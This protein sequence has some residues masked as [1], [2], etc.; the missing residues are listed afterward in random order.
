MKVAVVT[1]GNKGIG[2]AIVKGLCEKYEGLVYLTARDVGR[3]EAAVAE[4]KKLGLEPK[5][6]Q[7]DITDQESLDSFRDFIKKE[8]GGIDILVNN[9]AMA[10]KINATEPF[11]EK[12]EKTLYVNYFSLLKTCDTLFPLL[13]PHARV[14][15]LSSS[16]GHLSRIPGDELKKKLASPT[17]TIGQ[18]S[19][20]MKDFIQSAMENKHQQKGWPNFAYAAYAV[21]KVGV[22]ALTFI[23]QR[24][25]DA[26]SREDIVVNA[27][28]PGYV[29]TDMTSHMGPL[30]IE[31]GADAPLYLALLPDNVKSPSGNYIWCNREIVDWIN[32]PMP[33]PY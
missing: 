23:Q 15:N 26:D 17:L 27:V 22:S 7:L 19:E 18:L 13:C 28:H 16:A 20:L 9:A 4:L 2:Y 11:G 29:D 3:G 8:H 31:Q 30:T 32:G 24:A 25:F 5:F 14:V 33:G 6:H 12:A 1:G 10:Y 21:S